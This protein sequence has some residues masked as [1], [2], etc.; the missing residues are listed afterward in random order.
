M[1]EWAPSG[2]TSYL[3]NLMSQARLGEAGGQWGCLVCLRVMG[4]RWRALHREGTCSDKVRPASGRGPWAWRGRPRGPRQGRP[5]DMGPGGQPE[6][7]P[8]QGSQHWLRAAVWAGS[9]SCGR[10]RVQD[11]VVSRPWPHHL[12]TPM[13]LSPDTTTRTVSRHCPRPAGDKVT[14]RGGV[15]AGLGTRPM[16]LDAGRRRRGNYLT[17]RRGRRRGAGTTGAPQAGRP[18]ELTGGGVPARQ[19]DLCQ[20][21]IGCGHRVWGTAGRLPGGARSLRHRG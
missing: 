9:A 2:P 1:I 6:G 5:V 19:G 13:H 17:T 10:L 15:A 4:S 21:V 14:T 7:F 18:A 20:E 11:V 16:K 3:W 12:R 8:R